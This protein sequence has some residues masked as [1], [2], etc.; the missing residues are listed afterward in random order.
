MDIFWNYTVAI[1]TVAIEQWALVTLLTVV[2]VLLF[3]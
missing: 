3:K 2:V 1:S